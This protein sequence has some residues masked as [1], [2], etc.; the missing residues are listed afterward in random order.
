MVTDHLETAEEE[1]VNSVTHGLGLVLSLFGLWTLLQQ[2]WHRPVSFLAC[3]MFGS[4]IVTMYL[5][6][7]LYHWCQHPALKVRLHRLDHV[8]IN[9]VIAG[10]Y[11]PFCLLALP[12]GGMEILA[13]VWGMALAGILFVLLGG[14]R[15]YRVTMVMYFLMGWFAVVILPGL[16]RA[17]PLDG[18]L[19]MLAGGLLYTCGSYFYAT[20]KFNYSHAVWHL[21]VIFASGCHFVS[22]WLT[23]HASPV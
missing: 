2:F 16:C 6:S 3:A 19:W 21:F 18:L 14:V 9:L 23:A 12:G 20:H 11:T 8:S 5:M 1:V 10:S 17:M 7:T 4:C 13:A 22:V 15:Y